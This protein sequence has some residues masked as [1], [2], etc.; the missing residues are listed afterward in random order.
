M[1]GKSTSSAGLNRVRAA[2]RDP[3][4]YSFL[5]FCDAI[6]SAKTRDQTSQY[7]LLAKQIN[8]CGMPPSS[9]VR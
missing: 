6:R 1:R 7:E 8:D 4:L 9:A 2:L 5:A 3:K